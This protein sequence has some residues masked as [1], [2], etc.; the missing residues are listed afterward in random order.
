MADSLLKGQSV[1]VGITANFGG[2]ISGNNKKR[3]KRN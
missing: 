2:E 3:K 1:L